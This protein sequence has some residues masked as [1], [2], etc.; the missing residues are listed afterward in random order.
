VHEICP[1]E[2]L[3]LRLQDI[4]TQ[5]A[6]T[7][8]AAR[9]AHQYSGGH[10]NIERKWITVCR[11]PSFDLRPINALRPLLVDVASLGGPVSCSLHFSGGRNLVGKVI[12][13]KTCWRSEWRF[14]HPAR[15]LCSAW[16]FSS[17]DHLAEHKRRMA[18]HDRSNNRSFFAP[19]RFCLALWVSYMYSFGT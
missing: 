14:E 7:A 13:T 11:M 9:L 8:S 4:T 17:H 16:L 1:V 15:W 19:I 3:L 18:S 2:H 12:P 5:S 10:I 6:P